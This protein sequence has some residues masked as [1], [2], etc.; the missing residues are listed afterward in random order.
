MVDNNFSL[1][2]PVQTQSFLKGSNE[3]SVTSGQKFFNALNLSNNQKD[4]NVTDSFRFSQ[5]NTN[6]IFIEESDSLEKIS[7]NNPI[8]S[9]LL[10]GEI[11]ANK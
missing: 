9:A 3:Q 2:I 10:K 11:A 4:L 7:E 1:K 5:H 6:P 8:L